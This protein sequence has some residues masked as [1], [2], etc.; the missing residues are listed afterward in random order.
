MPDPLPLQFIGQCAEMFHGDHFVGRT[1]QDKQ[2]P[3][4][5]AVVLAF[6]RLQSPMEGNKPF[7]GG[8][9]TREFQHSRPAEAVAHSH[10]IARV[11]A[12]QSGLF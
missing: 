10:R 1:V 6:R 4:G 3:L 11:G 8:T 9:G 5:S 7:E 2:L 12:L